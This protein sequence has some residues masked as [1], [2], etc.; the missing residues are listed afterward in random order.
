VLTSTRTFS[1]AEEFAYNLQARKRAIIVGE[2]TGGGAHPGQGVSVPRGLTTFVPTDAPSAQNS[3]LASE[4]LL[5]VLGISSTTLVR[6]A[7]AQHSREP[8]WV[9]L[10]AVADGVPTLSVMY[11]L[12][13]HQDGGTGPFLRASRRYDSQS[14]SGS[15][16]RVCGYVQ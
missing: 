3:T 12:A 2:T 10:Y 7:E 6:P 13:Y 4:T 16:R 1:G 9:A 8:Y 14:R 15:A 5:I 11:L